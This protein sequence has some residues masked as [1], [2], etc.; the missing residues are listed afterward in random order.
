MFNINK[1]RLQT[2]SPIF[3]RIAVRF[4]KMGRFKIQHSADQSLIEHFV[5]ILVNGDRQMSRFLFGTRVH[6]SIV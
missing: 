2:P 5:S 3:V 1:L 6:Y 4:D